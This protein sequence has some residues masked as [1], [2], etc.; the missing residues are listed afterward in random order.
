MLLT[1]VTIMVFDDDA[2]ATMRMVMR[3]ALMRVPM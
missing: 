3:M 1:L 2:L